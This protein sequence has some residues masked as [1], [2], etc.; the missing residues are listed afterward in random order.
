MAL[1]FRSQ[2]LVGSW[3]MYKDDDR[4][5]GPIPEETMSFWKNGKFLISGDH[6]HKG[7][8]RINGNYLEFLL[9]KG[10]RTIRA[11]RQ[12]EIT[13]DE[14]KFKNKKTGWVYYKRISKK[15]MGFEPN[16]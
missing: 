6:P 5:N 3:E 4:P 8:Y 13:N 10:D 1:D 9:K 16:L 15:P 14:L 12:F 11:E 7:L 2:Q